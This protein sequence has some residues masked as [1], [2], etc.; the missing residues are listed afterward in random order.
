VKIF[1]RYLLLPLALLGLWL[2]AGCRGGNSDLTVAE[3]DEED[4][5]RGQV[6]VR[7]DRQ[8]EALASFLKVIVKRGE[9]PSP[10]SHLEA[11][12]LYLKH[13]KNPIR[14]SYHFEEYL[15]QQGPNSAQAVR[16]RE[17]I[18][19]AKKELWRSMAGDPLESQSKYMDLLEKFTKLQRENDDL[20]YEIATLRNGPATP[21]LKSVRAPANAEPAPL[22]ANTPATVPVTTA[23]E[24]S[25]ITAAPP[26]VRPIVTEAA[27]PPT[28]TVSRVNSPPAGGRTTPARPGS[29]QATAQAAPTA[30]GK[31][32]VVGQSEGLWAIARKY[33]GTPTQAN[34]R[35]IYEANKEVMKS[36]ND[37]RPGMVLKIP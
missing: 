8:Q 21:L 1:L 5:R 31:R 23:E 18:N 24:E 9:Q 6:L 7:Q 36:D 17:L 12:L 29:T 27:P 35:A 30:G 33:Y 26:P 15:A 32:H 19:T 4:Y 2:T 34:T 22:R 20:R 28:S 14:A 11:G 13:S 3:T 25:P 37:L 16:V 10:E